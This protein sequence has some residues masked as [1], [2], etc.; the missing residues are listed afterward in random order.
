MGIVVSGVCYSVQHDGCGISNANPITTAVGVCY[1]ANYF[2]DT[3]YAAPEGAFRGLVICIIAP[4]AVLVLVWSSNQPL[5]NLTDIM[6]ILG[7][8]NRTNS[9]TVFPATTMPA[10]SIVPV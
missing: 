1:L 8:T 6:D 7:C 9:A 3:Y 4:V 10:T 5:T 2:S